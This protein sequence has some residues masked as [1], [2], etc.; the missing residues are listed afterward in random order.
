MFIFCSCRVLPERKEGKLTEPGW[1][2]ARYMVTPS[3]TTIKSWARGEEN[4]LHHPTP[5]VSVATAHREQNTTSFTSCCIRYV[6]TVS[7]QSKALENVT[8]FIGVSSL[9]SSSES[10]CIGFDKS[11]IFSISVAQIDWQSSNM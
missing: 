9:N 11:T 8:D 2:S 4:V 5:M 7:K 10:L 3:I 6:F 1:T